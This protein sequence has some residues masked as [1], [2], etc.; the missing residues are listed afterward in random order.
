[1]VNMINAVIKEMFYLY[2]QGSTRMRFVF[3]QTKL[4]LFRF[5]N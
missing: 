1:M 4:P 5:L 2:S 3:E